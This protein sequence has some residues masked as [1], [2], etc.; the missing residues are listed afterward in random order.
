MRAPSAT[1]GGTRF[2]RFAH[3]DMLLQGLQVDEP[4]AVGEAAHVP[5]HSWHQRVRSASNMSTMDAAYR[6][7]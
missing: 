1:Y 3:D 7:A 4:H 6:V 2:A 5:K